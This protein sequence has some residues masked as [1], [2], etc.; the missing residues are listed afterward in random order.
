MKRLY[1]ILVALALA[2][3]TAAVS[4]TENRAVRPGDIPATTCDGT[5]I[6]WTHKK[7]RAYDDGRL[8]LAKDS[9][10]CVIA[11]ITKNE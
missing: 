10:G 9:T 3:C 6:E 7:Q 1:P 8:T 4:E 2:G 11:I 5:P